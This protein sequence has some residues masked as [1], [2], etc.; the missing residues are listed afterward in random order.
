[1][2]RILLVVP[3]FVLALSTT[4]SPR[5]LGRGGF[6]GE[7]CFGCYSYPYLD[8]YFPAMIYADSSALQMDVHPKQARI[9]VDRYYVGIVDDF[10]RLSLPLGP[11][12]IT[13]KLD[14]FKTHRFRPYVSPAH[15]LKPPY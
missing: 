2:R 4:A 8:P 12:E 11:H 5:G 10:H 9:F 7:F 13:L 15:P 3:L 6:R 14:G 1:M